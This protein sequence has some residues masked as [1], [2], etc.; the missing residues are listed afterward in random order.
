[1]PHITLQYYKKVGNNTR[2]TQFL[3]E[4]HDN[5]RVQMEDV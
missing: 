4:N 3:V 2:V 5:L 1:M